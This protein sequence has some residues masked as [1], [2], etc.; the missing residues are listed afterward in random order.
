RA[1]RRLSLHDRPSSLPLPCLPNTLT[2]RLHMTG[3][4][5]TT[6]YNVD[7]CHRAPGRPQRGQEVRVAP[8]M[9]LRAERKARE[10]LAVLSDRARRGRSG[11]AAGRDPAPD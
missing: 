4:C 10:I 3:R 11:P 1:N 6:P 9:V 8:V 7:T 2:E 5:P